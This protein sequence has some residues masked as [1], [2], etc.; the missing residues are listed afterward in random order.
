MDC[1]DIIS[2]FFG[3]NMET[4]KFQRI[5]EQASKDCPGAYNH[6]EDLRIVGADDKEHEANLDELRPSCR[7]MES[8]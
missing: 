8:L 2:F 7:T 4:E 6:D 3:I 5:V 1:I